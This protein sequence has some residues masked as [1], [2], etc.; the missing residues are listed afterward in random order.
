MKGLSLRT[1]VT[2]CVI[3]AVSAVGLPVLAHAQ[4]KATTT[5]Q[6]SGS[7]RGDE[8]EGKN[9]RYTT[10]PIK[11]AIYIIGENRTFDH[12]FATYV[13]R[14]GQSV[15]N[16]LSEGIIT[17]EGKPGPN[18]KKALQYTASETGTYSIHPPKTGP[19][20]TL[21]PENTDGAPTTAHFPT[22]AAAK[23]TEPALPSDDYKIL[24]TG[25]TGQAADVIDVRFPNP[26]ANHPFQLSAY[27]PYDSYTASPVH[28]FFQ[29][30]QETDCDITKATRQNPSGCQEDLWPWVE[31]TQGAGQNG[32]KQPAGFNDE[33]TGEGSTSMGF[34]N[35]QAGDA[36]YFTKLAD[37]YALD[38]NFHQAIEGGT[39][40]NHIMVGFGTGIYYADSNGN[41]ATPP[42]NQ[43]E[44]PNAQPGTNNYWVEDGYSG[45]SYVNC[46]DK[47]QPGVA[48]VRDYES[49]LPY[50]V[51]DACVKGAY[52]LVNNYN[53]GYLGTGVAAPLGPTQYTIPPSTQNNLALL[54]NAHHISWKY[55]GEGWAGGTE[56]GEA[57]TYCNICNPFL[58]S[59]QVMTNPNL[60]K[61]LQDIQ[62]LYDDIGSG[63]LPAVSIV[64][65]DGYLDGHPAS[66]KWDLYEGFVQKIVTMVQNNPELWKETA[67]FITEDEGGGYYDSGYIQPLDF[68]GDGTR[69]PLL[70]V[71]PFTKG[72]GV[73]HTYGDHV[74]W[75]KFVEANWGLETISSTSRDNLP[76]PITRRDN[77]YV[78]VNAPAISDLMDIFN[79]H[80]HGGG[81]GY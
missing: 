76:N 27:L 1:T 43:I 21:P 42:S 17:A 60:R 62:N 36:P 73:V 48:S 16:L 25:G 56:T 51:L 47:T 7:P 2:G 49:S 58:Y 66:S 67:I 54:L 44:N 33:T 53:P 30:W 20:A 22:I 14:P 61:N 5:V 37:E 28:R 64:K 38:D 41:P 52:Y 4:P 81:G 74:S 8:S 26:L 69:I 40:A 68:F 39:G 75:P 63:A 31:T 23:D 12:G 78:P 13:A 65:P 24:T 35:V 19:F 46:A 6:S 50:K 80:S 79:F 57:S 77:P 18:W 59:K 10:T 9:D 3:S 32:A 29:M 11:H 34:W 45:G 70:V 15:W 71:S 55:Y 72:V